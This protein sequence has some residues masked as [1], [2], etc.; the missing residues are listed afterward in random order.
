MRNK[1]L[2]QERRYANKFEYRVRPADY[3]QQIN[4]MCC[5]L[6][7]PKGNAKYLNSVK[8]AFDDFKKFSTK[9]LSSQIRKVIVKDQQQ[10]AFIED[11]IKSNTEDA[12]TIKLLYN[13]ILSDMQ[14]LKNE[15]I[16]KMTN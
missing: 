7:S 11:L 4:L 9:G 12:Q 1:N 16:K 6:E 3:M 8:S 5:I 10:I 14:Y 2:T 15:L 13:S